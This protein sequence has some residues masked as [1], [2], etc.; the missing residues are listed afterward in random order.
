MSTYQKIYTILG[1]DFSPWYEK[2]YTEEWKENPENEKWMDN[3]RPGEV[4]LFTDL[5]S[6]NHLYFGY[7]LAA[8]DGY[9][10]TDQK[11]PITRVESLKNLVAQK[12]L[13][14]NLKLPGNDFP[15][16]SI[17]TFVEWV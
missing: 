7:I 10:W 5:S 9:D 16:M 1:Y 11:E 17:I 15:P 4:Q 12:L 8:G 3:W 2:M 13:Q 6:S 14:S